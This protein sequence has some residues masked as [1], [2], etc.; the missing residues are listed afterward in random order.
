MS[1]YKYCTH[2]TFNL[3]TNISFGYDSTIIKNSNYLNPFC[4]DVFTHLQTK[5]CS[6]FVT[7]I[8]YQTS[9]KITEAGSCNN[10]IITVIRNVRMFLFDVI[11]VIK[12]SSETTVMCL[13]PFVASTDIECASFI[14]DL[15][16]NTDKKKY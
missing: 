5:N 11:I 16:L 15:L 7:L 8:R 14:S 2:C 12:F 10:Y 3:W 13:W 4:S 1:H 6:E 9:K